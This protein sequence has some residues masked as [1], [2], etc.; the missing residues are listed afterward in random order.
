MKLPKE[1]HPIIHAIQAHKSYSNNEYM[2]PFINWIESKGFKKNSVLGKPQLFEEYSRD[3]D[4]QGNCS[5]RSLED[6]D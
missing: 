6:D 4:V 5:A 3:T 2:E 1:P